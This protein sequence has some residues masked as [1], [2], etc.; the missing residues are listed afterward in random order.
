MRLQLNYQ[1]LRYF[2]LTATEGRLTAAAAKLRLSPSTISAQ[3]R[4]LE[5]QFGHALF[6]RRG[7]GL[8]LTERG[9]LVKA[10]ADDIFTLGEEL[11]DVMSSETAGRHAYHL[12]VGVSFNLPKLLSL[13]LLD[14]TLD[15]P[16][17]PVHLVI[18]EDDA[19]RL[20]GHIATHHLELVLSDQPV[21]VGADVRANC[22]LLLR[23]EIS[24]FGSPS[25]L[26]RLRGAFP[27]CIEG[28]PILL[29][30]HGSAMRRE[31]EG[32]LARMDL[33]PHVVA[34]FGDSALLK[35]FGQE[36]KGVFPAPTVVREQVEAMYDVV[37]LGVM[38][39]ASESVYAVTVQGR[40]NSPPVRAVVEAGKALAAL[41]ESSL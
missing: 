23:S 12:H 9:K 14:A 16:D 19:E 41:G 21:G 4:A 39:G 17:F 3:I 2:W 15:L 5:E 25:L 33:R 18:E 32:W 38:D 40:E 20:V 7:R 24:L 22:E 8:V 6:E 36:G 31:I 10:Y 26:P 37:H 34:E 29:P 30:L 27:Q 1:H 28:A 13:L 11:I 35:S